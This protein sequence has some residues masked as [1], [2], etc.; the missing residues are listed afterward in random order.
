ME[1][2][3]IEECIQHGC[4]YLQRVYTDATWAQPEGG[5]LE[6]SHKSS[7]LAVSGDL[8]HTSASCLQVSHAPSP[9]GTME[10]KLPDSD[11]MFSC[12]FQNLSA[13]SCCLFGSAAHWV[14]GVS[15]L[16][17]LLPLGVSTPSR[18]H[19]HSPAA[20]PN[21][22]LCWDS[23]PPDGLPGKAPHSQ[24]KSTLRG[25]PGFTPPTGVILGLWGCSFSHQIPGCAFPL[26]TPQST[27]T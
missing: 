20:T 10:S 14:S 26:D 27:G 2:A 18:L 15:S 1:K 21:A 23:P 9:L 5:V 4:L 19:R 3:D 12:Y 6:Q 13:C 7:E 16:S 8:I 24:G 25:P 22:C 11:E 17:S